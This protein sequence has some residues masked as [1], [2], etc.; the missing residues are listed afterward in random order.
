MALM[1]A[2]TASER[3]V[4]E[5]LVVRPQVTVPEVAA[6][7]S[8]PVSTAQGIIARLAEAGIARRLDDLGGKRGRPVAAYAARIPSA[9]I[10]C[11]L[12]GTS[13]V[14]CLVNRDLEV[15]RREESPIAVK[16]SEDLLPVIRSLIRKLS[17]GRGGNARVHGLALA[18]NAVEVGGHSLT[19]SVLPWLTSELPQRIANAIKIEVRLALNVVMA[20]EYRAW[21][22]S[23][24]DPL[25]LFRVAEGVSAHASV[26]G[27]AL[28]GAT[29]LAGEL[30]HVSTSLDGPV[31]GCGRR[32]CLETLCSGPAICRR[33]RSGLADAVSSELNAE[34]LESAMPRDGIEHIYRAWKNGDSYT[35]VAMEPIFD[36]LGWGLGL[37]VN[38][39]D[40]QAISAGGYVIADK[41]EWLDEIRRRAERWTL[42]PAKRD[43]P[44]QPAR[45]TIDDTLRVAALHYFYSSTP[46]VFEPGAA[47]GE[48]SP[49]LTVQG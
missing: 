31:C 21:P 43:L 2:A 25:V 38:L 37:V 10:A 12:D 45:T 39:Y 6:R 11:L 32:G 36:Q 3:P 17:G 40:P 24:P 1:F 13:L 14:G 23:P 18:L 28:V 49:A 46:R 42:H 30:G 16:R 15:V 48:P 27:K 9:V 33:L 4:F 35:R 26:A 29:G 5:L 44:L 47:V 20:A 41:P 19:S 8:L 7:L 22:E 34:F